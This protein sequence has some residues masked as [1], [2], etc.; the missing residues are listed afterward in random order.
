MTAVIK[1]GYSDDRHKLKDVIPLKT[2]YVVQFAPSSLC[3]L[4]CKYCIQSSKTMQKRQVMTWQ[5]F[6]ILCHQMSEF[7][8]KLKQ[9]N[10]AGWGEPLVNKNLPKMVAHIKD[11]GIAEKV[12]IINPKVYAGVIGCGCRFNP[13][14]LAGNVGTE[15]Y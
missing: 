13:Y 6:K 2:P 1:P 4:Q 15:V 14:L 7:D 5:M 3:N 8:E 11:M 12:A 10:M 9:V